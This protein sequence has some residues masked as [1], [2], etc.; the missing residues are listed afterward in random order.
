[1]LNEGSLILRQVKASFDSDANGGLSV[2][3][4]WTAVG[5]EYCR[6][7][8]LRPHGESVSPEGVESKTVYEAR[9]RLGVDIAPSDRVQ[10]TSGALPGTYNVINV[11]AGQSEAALM[12]V[13]LEAINEQ[14]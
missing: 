4:A 1:V 12:I 3:N 14:S 5:R 7:R 11:V 10:I 8:I 9:F 6:I 13:L 2:T